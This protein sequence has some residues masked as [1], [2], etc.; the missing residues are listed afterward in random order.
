MKRM[1]KLFAAALIVALICTVA[2]CFTACGGGYKVTYVIPSDATGTAPATATYEKYE[3]FKLPDVTD[4]A[5]T[6]STMIGWQ[7]AAGNFYATGSTFKMGA[8][9]M[10]F[11]AVFQGEELARSFCENPGTMNFGGRLIGP[12]PAYTIFRLDKTWSAD[13]E[14][15]ATFSHFE[16]TWDLTSA[17]V[18][19]M[20]LTV[21]DGVTRNTDVEIT[22]GSS[23]KDFTYTLTH[24]GD[25]GGLKYHVNHVSKYALIKAYN[26]AS[27][28][29]VTLPAEPNFT[30]TFASGNASA[31]GTAPTALSGKVGATLTMPAC[32][33]TRDGYT[34]TGWTIDRATYAANSSYTV[35]SADLIAT[36]G[37]KAA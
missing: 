33:F 37:W 26:D 17:G 31:T 9:D 10:T 3:E 8:S 7:D 30:V 24:P 34:F 29:S 15:V 36:A 25:R 1:R 12:T 16:G 18:L 22:S 21:Q 14:G 28:S 19:S 6:N 32:T 23:D 13:A 4:A 5:K 27:G 35:V 11:T 20:K 2:V